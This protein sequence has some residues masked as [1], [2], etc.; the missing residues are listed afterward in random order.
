M[1]AIRVGLLVL[2]AVSGCFAWFSARSLDQYEVGAEFSAKAGSAE[3]AIRD[4][5]ASSRSGSMFYELRKVEVEKALRA[6][7]ELAKNDAEREIQH[8][9]ELLYLNLELR[10]ARER[11]LQSL[12]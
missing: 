1:N 10:R 3:R 5:E 11:F 7:A 12:R 9:L 2:L 4:L 8:N 6:S